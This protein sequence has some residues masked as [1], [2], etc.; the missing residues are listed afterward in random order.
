MDAVYLQQM[1]CP[2]PKMLKGICLISLGRVGTNKKPR[3]TGAYYWLQ[4]VL[5]LFLVRVTLFGYEAILVFM[6]RFATAIL[7]FLVFTGPF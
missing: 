6:C 4:N 5:F 3:D 1:Y 7:D 2:K